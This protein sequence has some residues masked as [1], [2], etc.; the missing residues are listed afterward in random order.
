MRYMHP[1]LTTL[2]TIQ[3]QWR[4]EACCELV[5]GSDPLPLPPPPHKLPPPPRTYTRTVPPLPAH[6]CGGLYSPPSPLLTSHDC[7]QG[8]VASCGPAKAQAQ[9]G[10]HDSEQQWQHHTQGLARGACQPTNLAIIG[11]G[12]LVVTPTDTHSRHHLQICEHHRTDGMIGMQ[13][14]PLQG[15]GFP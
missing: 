11:G 5:G 15:R 8:P 6:M 7:V 9:A 14:V 3:D 12:G 13:C 2:S 4:A 1:P 10:A